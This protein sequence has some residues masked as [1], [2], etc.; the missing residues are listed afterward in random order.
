MALNSNVVVVPAAPQSEALTNDIRPIRPPVEIPSGWEWLWWTLGVI[1]GVALLIIAIAWFRRWLNKA[2]AQR[3]EIEPPHIRARRR[4]EAAGRLLSDPRAFCSEVSDTLRLYLEE[5]FQLRAPERTTDEFLRDL[6]NTNVLSENQKQSLARFLQQ[7]DLVKFARFEPPEA[8]LLELR[9][10]ALRLVD[11][12]A[13]DVSAQAPQSA[14]TQTA[15]A[16]APAP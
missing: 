6:Q 2:P 13:P 12:T 10:Y 16:G 15:Q 7:C 1:V 4:L 3:V 14:A 8:E 9:N 5:R 11:E